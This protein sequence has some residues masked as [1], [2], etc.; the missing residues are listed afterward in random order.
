MWRKINLGN[1]K[2]YN[3]KVKQANFWWKGPKLK[4]ENGSKIEGLENI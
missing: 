1:V 3:L 4:L 2:V